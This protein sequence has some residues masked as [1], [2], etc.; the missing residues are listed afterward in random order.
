M[1]EK[2]ITDW[3]QESLEYFEFL[4][5]GVWLGCRIDPYDLAKLYDQYGAPVDLMFVR[6]QKEGRTID[7]DRFEQ[8]IKR[9]VDWRQ[10]KN[11]RWR[12]HRI[13]LCTVAQTAI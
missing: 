3:Q 5:T 13:K 11:Q 12:I 9:I 8:W 7:C 4:K 2:T 6:L 10:G 1:S